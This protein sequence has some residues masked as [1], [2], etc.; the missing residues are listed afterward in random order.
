M[1]VFSLG[2][3]SPGLCAWLL[4]NEAKWPQRL[5]GF[6]YK[7]LNDCSYFVNAEPVQGILTPLPFF[8]N[9]LPSRERRG[10]SLHLQRIRRAGPKNQQS[11]SKS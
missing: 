4:L 7:K 3:F 9:V 11:F 6:C 5:R 8:D 1:V 10:A 2:L